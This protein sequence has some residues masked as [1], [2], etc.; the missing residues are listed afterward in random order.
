MMI[1]L[2]NLSIS[3]EKEKDAHRKECKH[4]KNKY[5]KIIQDLEERVGELEENHASEL[6][7]MA[8]ESKFSVEK[9]K[10]QV[11]KSQDL[12]SYF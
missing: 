9:L 10:V 12:L 3:L 2:E 1:D 7:Q 11:D 4:L 5:L 8:S 6:E